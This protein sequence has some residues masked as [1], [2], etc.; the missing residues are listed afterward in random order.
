ME[1][2][3]KLTAASLIHHL[4]NDL[5]HQSGLDTLESPEMVDLA[6]VGTGLG[7]L[8]NEFRFVQQGNSYWDST[9]WDQFPRPFLDSNGLAYANAMAAWIRDDHKPDWVSDLPGDIK[10]PTQKS[11]K[12]LFKTNDCFFQRSTDAPG[13]LNQ[14]QADWL[15][16]ASETSISRQVIA[17][18]HLKKDQQLRDRQESLLMIKLR[19][20]DRPVVLHSISAVES[21]H[22]NTAGIAEELRRL[23]DHRDDEIRAKAIIALARLGQLDE[24]SV[25]CATQMIDSPVKFVVFAGVL[26]LSTLQEVSEPVLQVANRGLVHSLQSCDYEFV[27]LFIA[28]LSRWLKDPKSH[29]EELLQD[30][31]PGYLEIALEGLETIA[32]QQSA[33]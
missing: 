6:V 5:L 1:R 11:I 32:E 18:R 26:A 29:L 16:M 25:V 3:P 30:D 31:Q 22:L 23:L 2:E 24:S 28:A 12:F 13:L 10:K 14:S 17:I 7:A 9:V 27:N 15:Q 33:A 8:Q 20:P 4:V 19:S 21:L